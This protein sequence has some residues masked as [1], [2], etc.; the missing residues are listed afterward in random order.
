M[1]GK[2]RISITKG[3]ECRLICMG[4]MAERPSFT[5]LVEVFDNVQF[6]HKW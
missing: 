1:I 4:K 2:T 3:R 6:F 5:N